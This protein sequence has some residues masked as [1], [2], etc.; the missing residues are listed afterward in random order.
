MKELSDK[1]RYLPSDNNMS[2]LKDMSLGTK[3]PPLLLQFKPSFDPLHWS[4]GTARKI[5]EVLNHMN[6]GFTSCWTIRA[7]DKGSFQ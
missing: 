2:E 4:L 6:A 5:E 7:E 1:I 3:A